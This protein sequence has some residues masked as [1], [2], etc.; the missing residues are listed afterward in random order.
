MNWLVYGNL[1]PAVADALTRHKQ[2][3]QLA[4]DIGLADDASPAEVLE[5]ARV[6]QL[7]VITADD[8]IA[9]APYAEEAARFGRTIV[10][11]LVDGQDVEQD[12]AIDRLFAR[13][14][15]LSAGR[16]YTVTASRVKIRQLPGSN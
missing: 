10:Y 4:A 1:T 16:L 2:K 9:H 6:A 11:L 15:R 5:A 7:E 8:A 13:Y 12:D 14:K 3:V